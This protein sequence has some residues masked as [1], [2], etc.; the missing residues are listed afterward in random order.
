[1]AEREQYTTKVLVAM[2][3][4]QK[5]MLEQACSAMDESV[6]AFIRKACMDRIKSVAGAGHE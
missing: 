2:K 6:N 4:S 5:Q 3:P 1:M